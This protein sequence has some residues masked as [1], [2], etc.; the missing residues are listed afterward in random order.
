MTNR[1]LNLHI[2]LP[3]G[4]PSGIREAHI[5]KSLVRVIEVPNTSEHLKEFFAMAESDEP[6]VYFLLQEE[7]GEA[8]RKLYIGQTSKVKSRFA[9]HHSEKLFWQKALVV[10]SR[11]ESL[12]PAHLFQL[13]QLCIQR[14]RA[15]GRFHIQNSNNG[16]KYVL[17]KHL[18]AD[19][20]DLFDMSNLLLTTLGLD[21]FTTHTSDSAAVYRCTQVGVNARAQ[22]SPEGMTILKGSTARKTVT[23]SFE[24]KSFYQTRLKLLDSGILKTEGEHLVYTEDFTFGSPSAAAAITI[25]NNVN[26]WEAWRTEDGKTLD[27]VIRKAVDTG[28]AE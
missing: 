3:S 14:A 18:Q 19:C 13:E 7:V 16:Q 26:G 15:A 6:C 27:E 10:S 12:S 25:G 24:A 22:Y 17:T 23:P 5:T 21:L 11:A 9:T 8:K 2:F 4:D 1:A 28:S 20:E